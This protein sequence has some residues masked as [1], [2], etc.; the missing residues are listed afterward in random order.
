MAYTT[1][2]ECKAFSSL[3]EVA[4]KTDLQLDALIAK[5][6]KIINAFTRQNFNAVVKSI[7]ISGTGSRMMMLPE[8][9]AIKT[10]VE[11]LEL[12]D[13][14][15]VVLNRE[16]IKDVFNRSWYLISDFTFDVPRTRAA[17]GRFPSTE[18][19]IEVTGTWGY[20]SVPS[21]VKDA[22][23]A[24]VEKIVAEE[25]DIKAKSSI[26]QSERIGDYRYDKFAQPSGKVNDANAELTSY[27]RLLL[28]PFHKPLRP[29]VPRGK[30]Q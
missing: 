8:R 12:D 14:G 7:R 9:L 13:G 29:R 5:A 20:A 18:D 21:E 10:K 25:K 22:T 16:E 24:I 28:R 2:T 1:A 23:C 30:I 17:F 19:N 27:A 3:A 26:F 11:F 4:A 6:E 15:D